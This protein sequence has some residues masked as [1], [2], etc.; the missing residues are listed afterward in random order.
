MKVSHFLKKSKKEMCLA[1]EKLK[2]FDNPK[3][4][5]SE[6][7]VH[8][9]ENGGGQTAG[10]QAGRNFWRCFEFACCYF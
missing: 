2:I 10:R 3:G 1:N 9:N 6:R 8:H 7:L 5:G 4:E